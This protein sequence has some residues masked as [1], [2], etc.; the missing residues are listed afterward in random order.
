MANDLSCVT[1]SKVFLFFFFHFHTHQQ[2]SPL[3]FHSNRTKKDKKPKNDDDDDKP[4]AADAFNIIL[5]AAVEH[6]RPVHIAECPPD[7]MALIGNFFEILKI[8]FFL[9]IFFYF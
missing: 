4:D 6:V 1:F 8:S 3:S 9:T 7:L 5:K 2:N